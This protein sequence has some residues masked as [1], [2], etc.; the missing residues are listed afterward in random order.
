MEDCKRDVYRVVFFC[1]KEKGGNRTN[2]LSPVS[3]NCVAEENYKGM[4]KRRRRK[5]NTFYVLYT[6]YIHS[7]HK[8][9][10]HFTTQKERARVVSLDIL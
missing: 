4:R 6:P 3:K 7:N 8:H 5:K 2:N 9:H 10:S 1:L